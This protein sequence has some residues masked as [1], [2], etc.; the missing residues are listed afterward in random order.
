MPSE[1]DG[2]YKAVHMLLLDG[3]GKTCMV[4]DAKMQRKAD[5]DGHTAKSVWT[6]IGGK[7]T[8]E[9]G[10]RPWATLRRVARQKAGLDLA[11][12]AAFRPVRPHPSCC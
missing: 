9:D 4:R 11:D 3:S 5:R 10:S 12:A 1:S 7:V 2:T 6:N 8:A